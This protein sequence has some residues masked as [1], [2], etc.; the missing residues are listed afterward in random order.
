M[1]ITE[2]LVRLSV[3]VENYNDIISDIEQALASL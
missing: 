2:K 1:H 3:G